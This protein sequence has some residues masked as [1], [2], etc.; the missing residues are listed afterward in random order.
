[1]SALPDEGQS[2]HSLSGY[3]AAAH[4][5]PRAPMMQSPLSLTLLLDNR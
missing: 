4:S 5:G 1:M 2:A 3:Q